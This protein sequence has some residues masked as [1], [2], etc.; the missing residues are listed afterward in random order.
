MNKA[1]LYKING[2]LAEELTLNKSV[3]DVS[4]NDDLIYQAVQTQLSNSRYPIANSKTRS[5]VAGSTKKPW[6]QKG[7]GRARVGSIRNPLWKGGGVAFGPKSKRNFIKAF[8]K[9]M[10]QLALKQALSS[11]LVDN[12]IL[13]VE[14]I[15]ISDGKTKSAEK[16]ISNFKEINGSVLLITLEKNA[17]NQL[18]FRNIPYVKLMTC[19]SV[20]ILD[21]LKYNWIVFARDAIKNI[22]DR[23]ASISKKS[24]TDKNKVVDESKEE[25]AV[26]SI[27]ETEKK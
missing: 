10:K 14:K 20:N 15:D 17:Q 18:A 27:L 19:D 8:P 2:E 26:D 9:K 1:K 11:R 7:T 24:K 13:I 6:R 16:F 22:E 4:A 23:Y 12:N 3:F 25:K 21:I 5:D